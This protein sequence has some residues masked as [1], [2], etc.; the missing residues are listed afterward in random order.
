MPAVF[1]SLIQS[2]FRPGGHGN[3]EAVVLEGDRLVHWW[4]DD[5]VPGM[6]WRRGRVI[7]DG[8]AAWPGALI[9]SDF[10]SGEHGNFEVIAPVRVGDRVELRHYWHDN[11][12][13]SLPWQPAGGG[14]IATN[15]AGPASLIQSDFG[16]GDHGNFELVVPLTAAGGSEVHLCHYWH[17]NSD[18]SLPWQPGQRIPTT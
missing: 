2:D 5:G 3:L 12:D 7:I 6:P 11:S 14:P 4:R 13:V 1:D 16:S 9:Q 10:R 15:V 8:G 17:D 18:V